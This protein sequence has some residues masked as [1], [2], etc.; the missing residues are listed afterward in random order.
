MAQIVSQGPKRWAH[1]EILVVKRDSEYPNLGLEGGFKRLKS[2]GYRELL[3][4]RYLGGLES[5]GRFEVRA[6]NL[7]QLGP[8]FP[9]L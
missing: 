2:C 3:S 4:R 7:E 6:A 1:A 5:L 8:G 9:E